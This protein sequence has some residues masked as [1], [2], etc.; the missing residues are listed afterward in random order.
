ML[1]PT[2]VMLFKAAYYGYYGYENS[3][4]GLPESGPVFLLV[5]LMWLA[6]IGLVENRL[7]ALRGH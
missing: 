3:G 7:R 5:A 1:F 4:Y 2:G 6:A